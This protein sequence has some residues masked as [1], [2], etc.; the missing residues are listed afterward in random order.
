MSALTWREVLGT[1]TP[2]M[3][4]KSKRAALQRMLR[5]HPNWSDRRIASSVHTIILT[6]D[7]LDESVGGGAA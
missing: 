4:N 7:D 1:T 6:E 2:A 3:Q 5:A